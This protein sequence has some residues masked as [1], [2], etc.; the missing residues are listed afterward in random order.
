LGSVQHIGLVPEVSCPAEHDAC[1]PAGQDTEQ[2]RH[3]LVAGAEQVVGWP[4]GTKLGG[5]CGRAPLPPL[6]LHFGSVQ[7]IGLSPEVSCP[8][9]HEAC[10]PAGQDTE[11][12]LHPLV[13]AAEQEAA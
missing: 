11:Q 3:P 8:M 12:P 9:L 7:H 5:C 4:C 2:L 6:Q 13:G 1:L 10:W